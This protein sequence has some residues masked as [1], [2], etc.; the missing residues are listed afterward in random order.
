MSMMRNALRTG[1]IAAVSDDTMSRSA[2]IR[3]NSR[4]TRNARSDRSTFIGKF[5]GPRATRDRVTTMQSKTFQPFLTNGWNQWAKALMASS[6]VKMTVKKVS[7]ASS[8]LPTGVRFP[9]LSVVS[10][11]ASAA[12]VMKFCSVKK[13]SLLVRRTE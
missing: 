11:C 8:L 10:I 13:I 1:D 9:S 6:T 12:L 5:S 3:P 2:P 4:T 7:S